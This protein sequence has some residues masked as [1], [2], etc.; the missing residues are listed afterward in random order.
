MKKILLFISFLGI[1]ASSFAQ[2][3][4]TANNNAAQ[5]AQTLVGTGVTIS[6][7]TLNCGAAP[8]GSPNYASG[9][10]M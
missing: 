1:Y 9:F 7:P 10:L 8:A 6:N 5:L 3:N 2:V 4:I